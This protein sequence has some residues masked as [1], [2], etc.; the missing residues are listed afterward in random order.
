M[1]LFKTLIGLVIL[2]ALNLSCGFQPMY[3]NQKGGEVL[4]QLAAV[5]VVPMR[6]LL[7]VEM[8]NRLLDN[9]RPSGKAYAPDYQLLVEIA[10]NRAPLITEADSQ[11]RRFKIIVIANYR[12]VEI[13]SDTVL[14]TGTARAVASY[15]V[16]ETS[17]YASSVAEEEA[18]LRGV[19]EVSQQIVAGLSIF[20]KQLSSE[21]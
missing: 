5:D 10:T 1:W 17:N 9:L 21:L 4:K 15:N 8:Y 3:G 11:V 16:V 18:Q 19:R 13:G 12:L 7:G 20:F 2:S 14:D 6:G